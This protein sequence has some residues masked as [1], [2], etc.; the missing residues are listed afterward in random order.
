MQSRWG[1]G[2]LRSAPKAKS[3]SPDPLPPIL[4]AFLLSLESQSVLTLKILSAAPLA[5]KEYPPQQIFCHKCLLLLER[6]CFCVLLYH[7]HSP[8][9]CAMSIPTSRMRD[10]YHGETFCMGPCYNEEKA[11]WRAL[12]SHKDHFPRL[13]VLLR[14]ALV[15]VPQQC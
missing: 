8:Q 3:T 14:Y 6:S 2:A 13:H 7:V 1:G 12:V 11:F 5:P 15:L 4:P 9:Q 10:W